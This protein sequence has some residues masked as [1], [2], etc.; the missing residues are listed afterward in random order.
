MSRFEYPG[1]FQ[2]A[3]WFEDILRANLGDRETSKRGEEETL[4]AV[5]VVPSMPFCP[6][7]GVFFMPFSGHYLKRPCRN[8]SHQPS[9]LVFLRRINAVYDLLAENKSLF[10]RLLQGNFGVTPYPTDSILLPIPG[11]FELPALFPASRNTQQQPTAIVELYDFP[12]G[13]EGTN[14]G[15]GQRHVHKLRKRGNKNG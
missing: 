13:L 1:L 15:I 6:C 2:S 7:P 5:H 8:L 3:E 11:V 12:C 9:F 14:L 10:S 4:K